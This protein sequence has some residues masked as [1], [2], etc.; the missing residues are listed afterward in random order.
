MY[1]RKIHPAA[2]KSPPNRN[3]QDTHSFHVC[4]WVGRRPGMDFWVYGASVGSET[5]VS[6]TEQMTQ[7]QWNSYL[8][9]FLYFPLLFIYSIKVFSYLDCPMKPTRWRFYYHSCY[10]QKTSRTRTLM[11]LSDGFRKKFP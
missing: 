8:S 3:H 4:P 11:M 10:F 6:T 2:Q 7:I 5:A 1:P 9:F